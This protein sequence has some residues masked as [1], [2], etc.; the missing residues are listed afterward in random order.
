MKMQADKRK[1]VHYEVGNVVTMQ[2][3]KKNSVFEGS[4]L[5]I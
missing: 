2:A 4:A 3:D 1:E 5:Q